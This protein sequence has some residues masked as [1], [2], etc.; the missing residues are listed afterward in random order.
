MSLATLARIAVDVPFLNLRFDFALAVAAG[1]WSLA[2]L[3][4]LPALLS[5]TVVARQGRY[6]LRID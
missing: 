5:S 1:L 6:G 3:V 2:C 4:I